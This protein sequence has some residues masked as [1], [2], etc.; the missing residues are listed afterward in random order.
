MTVCKWCEKPIEIG[1]TIVGF[2]IV[3]ITA[4]NQSQMAGNEILFHTAC[5][6]ERMGKPKS[7]EIIKP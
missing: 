5:F 6:L 4:M 3:R 7:I 2:P 1:Q